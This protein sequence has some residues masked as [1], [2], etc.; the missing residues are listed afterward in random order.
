MKQDLNEMKK[1][2]DAY[3]NIKDLE[4]T[5]I[6]YNK[7]KR[8]KNFNISLMF[9]YL[10][11]GF[12][13]ERVSGPGSGAFPNTNLGITFAENDKGERILIIVGL[14]ILP[15]DGPICSMKINGEKI[16]ELR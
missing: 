5:N 3:L 6:D 1:C 16:I 9:Y 10:L 14:P 7:E 4:K 2:I 12:G 8:D 11:K 15:K 13:Y